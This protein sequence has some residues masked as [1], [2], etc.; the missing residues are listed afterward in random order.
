MNLPIPPNEPAFID[1][2]LRL[3]ALYEEILC[4]IT[5]ARQNDCLH[6]IGPLIQSQMKSIAA[7]QNGISDPLYQLIQ[8]GPQVDPTVRSLVQQQEHLLTQLNAAL[9]EIES[10]LINQ[11]E[12]LHRRIHQRGRHST[13]TRAYHKQT[14]R[15]SN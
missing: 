8:A 6:Q 13:V 10:E 12:S 4:V 15:A 9:P 5:D 3:N 7:I 2:L 14:T 11:K 1:Q